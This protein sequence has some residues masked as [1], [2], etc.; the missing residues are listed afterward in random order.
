MSENKMPPPINKTQVEVRRTILTKQLESALP[1]EES[2]TARLNGV[3]KFIAER[4]RLLEE[5]DE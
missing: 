3:K 2:L 1:A 4:R 5:L